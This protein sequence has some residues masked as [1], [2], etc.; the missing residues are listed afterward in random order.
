MRR[1]IA[2]ASL[3]TVIIASL[4]CSL[5]Q[6]QVVQVARKS[7]GTYSPEVQQTMQAIIQKQSQG[8]KGAKVSINRAYNYH[9]FTYMEPVDGAKLIAVD[10]SFSNYAGGFDLDDV[11]IVDG[12]TN[13]SYGSNPDIVFLTSEGVP[14]PNNEPTQEAGAPI[15]VVLIYAVRESTTAIK[16]GYWGTE[17]LEVPYNLQDSGPEMPK[18]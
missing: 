4:A 13:E 7:I 8:L 15:R 14:Y 9:G 18:H 10:A 12:T 6:P 17:I 2:L 11:D 5:T 1:I 3:L 16:L